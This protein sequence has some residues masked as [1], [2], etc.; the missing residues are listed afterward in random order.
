M[1]SFSLLCASSLLAFT[2]YRSMQWQQTASQH[3]PGRQGEG[4]VEP[5]VIVAKPRQRGQVDPTRTIGIAG[6]HPRPI[7]ACQRCG[8]NCVL[9]RHLCTGHLT[10]PVS[11]H[12]VGVL[13]RGYRAQH[14]AVDDAVLMRLI[15]LPPSRWARGRVPRRVLPCSANS[16]GALYG[17]W[18]SALR[19]WALTPPLDRTC[20]SGRRRARLCCRRTPSWPE[21]LSNMIFTAARG[22]G[23][24]LARPRP[25]RIQSAAAHLA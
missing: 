13:P 6:P 24:L 3:V 25:A 9:S 8:Q 21:D 20:G 4:V 11:F 12:S 10:M 7:F 1:P 17:A 14:P 15:P 19:H 18:P 23:A 5:P 22:A 2:S 16:A